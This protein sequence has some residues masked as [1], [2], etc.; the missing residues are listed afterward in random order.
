MTF[1]TPWAFTLLSLLAVLIVFYLFKQKYEPKKISTTFLWEQVIRNQEATKWNS[2]LVQQLLFYLQALIILLLVLAL[3]RPFLMTE[4]QFASK[5]VYVVDTSASM[6]A[7]TNSQAR[8]EEIKQQMKGRLEKMGANTE[9]SLIAANASPQ[10]LVSSSKSREAISAL[11]DLPLSYQSAN[12]TDSIQ[13][14]QS[15]LAD[16]GGVVHVYTDQLSEEKVEEMNL[17]VPLYVHNRETVVQ[18]VGITS[19]GVSPADDESKV[20]ALVSLHEPVKQESGLPV[21]ISANG[22]VLKELV[23]PQHEMNSL[24]RNLPKKAN[25]EATISQ[26]DDYKL[27]NTAYTYPAEQRK[28][29][30]YALGD[31]SSFYLKALQAQGH[32][33]VRTNQAEQT[34]EQ[35]GIYLIEN[36]PASEWPNGPKIVVNP[37]AGGPFEVGKEVELVYQVK[38]S[39]SSSLLRYVEMESVYVRK[40]R[41]L[42]SLNNL[43]PVVTSGETPLIAFGNYQGDKMLLIAFNLSNSDWPLSPS[44]PILLQN[45]VEEMIQQYGNIGNVTPGEIVDVQLHSNTQSIYIRNDAGKLVA[46]A[47]AGGELYFPNKPGLYTF[48]EQAEGKSYTRTFIIQPNEAEMF[49]AE[50]LSFQMNHTDKQMT[51]QGKYEWWPYLALLA[52]VVLLVEMEVYRH[53]FSNR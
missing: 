27:D 16:E 26:D 1:L 8:F 7:A 43:K 36:L 31:V 35:E 2:K 9:V 10:L 40:A 51:E 48:E 17:T 5:E 47:T 38:Q 33:V 42:G 13:L 24:I 23:I 3:T 15:M 32:E 39:E 6:L 14:A 29:V 22:E 21:T 28:P 44:F 12:L 46:S 52:L 30:I 34:D 49:F 53:R 19:F 11:E 4:E 25:Y 18:N 50:Q 41:L 37:K 20:N 45:T